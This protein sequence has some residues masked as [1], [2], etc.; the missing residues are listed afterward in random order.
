MKNSQ[1]ILS[2]STLALA[3]AGAAA[4]LSA[5]VTTTYSGLD[6]DWS[7][8]ASWNNGIPAAGD[9]A[10][11]QNEKNMV[12]Y[13]TLS[14]GVINSSGKILRLKGTGETLTMDNLGSTATITATIVDL[15]GTTLQFTDD[16]TITV[17]SGKE[18]NFAGTLQ[19]TGTLKLSGTTTSYVK[20][21]PSGTFAVGRLDLSDFGYIRFD[22]AGGASM[23]GATVDTGAQA[24][25][26]KNGSSFSGLGGASLEMDNAYD[27]IR[28]N[29]GETINLGTWKVGATYLPIGLY[30]VSSGTVSGVDM[31]VVFAQSNV[32]FNVT[33]AIPEP[34]S[35]ALLG[36]GGLLLL[37]GR[38]RRA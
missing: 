37:S 11:I 2:M 7:T 29:T 28:G 26:F 25:F 6:G 23:S 38:K 33:T 9:T 18:L 8:P 10:N 5:A 34:A 14:V 36:M 3:L 16:L 24:Y 19:G 22:G 1:S 13:D 35:L 30:N 21:N 15:V 32:S 20:S 12:G 4:P 31:G 27:V 17:N